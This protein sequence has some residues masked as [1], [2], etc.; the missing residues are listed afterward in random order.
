MFCALRLNSNNGTISD[1]RAVLLYSGTMS[2]LFSLSETTGTA[3]WRISWNCSSSGCRQALTTCCYQGGKRKWKR[4]G[5]W[6]LKGT[7]VAHMKWK[8]STRAHQQKL[9]ETTPFSLSLHLLTG[10]GLIKCAKSLIVSRHLTSRRSP[11]W[12]QSAEKPSVSLLCPA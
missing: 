11:L 6:E 9:E 2:I 1:S 7:R 5:G 8:H 10:S 4:G 12:I 3:R